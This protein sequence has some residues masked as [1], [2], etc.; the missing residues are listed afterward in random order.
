M[1]D[2]ASP[3]VIAAQNLVRL[4]MTKLEL[5][6][7][8]AAKLATRLGFTAYSSPQRVRR[9]LSGENEPD[10]E[11]TLQLLDIVGAINWEALEDRPPSLD[12][13]GVVEDARATSRRAREATQAPRARRRGAA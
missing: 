1:L 3:F 12:E 6:E 2:L 5:G 9:W 4:A 10:Y 11:A 8:D 13:A 7:K